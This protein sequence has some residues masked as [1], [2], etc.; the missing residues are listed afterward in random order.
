[1]RLFILITCLIEL[2]AG[3]VF[4]VCPT[5][6]PEFAQA[7]VMTLAVVRIYGGAAITLGWYAYMVWKN[8]APGPAMGFLK[9]F[10]VFQLLVAIA[11]Y[12]G[13]AGGIGNMLGGVVLHGVMWLITVYFMM[14]K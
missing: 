12:W 9:T 8:F 2:L 14:R 5:I 7:E 10:A 6:I 13:Y 11:C 3:I 4:F 1:M